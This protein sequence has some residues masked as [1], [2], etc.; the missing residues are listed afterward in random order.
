MLRTWL[1]S[2]STCYV[3]E[4]LVFLQIL[5]NARFDVEALSKELRTAMKGLGIKTQIL[6]HNYEYNQL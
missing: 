1:C 4:F 2:Q 5:P 3:N 6:R